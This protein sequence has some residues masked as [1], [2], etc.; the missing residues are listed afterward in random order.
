M[1]LFG[2]LAAAGVIVL[3]VGLALIDNRVRTGFW[4]P[5]TQW[6]RR[7]RGIPPYENNSRADDDA[8]FGGGGGF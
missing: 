3:G 4:T 1:A 2:F 6:S 5:D 7:W 8:W